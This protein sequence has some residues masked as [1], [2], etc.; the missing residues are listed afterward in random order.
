MGICVNMVS[1]KEIIPQI[2]NPK[3]IPRYTPRCNVG[4]VVKVY[5]GIN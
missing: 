2:E 1:P 3:S 5:D 4:R